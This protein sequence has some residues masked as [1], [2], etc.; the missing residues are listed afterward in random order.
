M[1]IQLHRWR[2]AK[3]IRHYLF[4]AGL[5]VFAV[6]IYFYRVPSDPPGFYIDESSI[7]YNAHTISHS[8]GDEY[9]V[10]WPLYFRAFGEFKNPTLVYLLAL[11]F[12][13]TGPSIL[14]ARV[15]C[16][17][18]GLTAALLLAVLAWKLSGQFMVGMLI[19]LSAT[20]TPWL[21]ESSRLVFEAAAYPLI[22][23]A[24]LLALHRATGR[25]VW[26][27]VDTILVATTLALLT[28]SYS[29]GRLLGPLLALGLISFAGKRN[30]RA[31]ATTLT[32]YAVTLLPMIVFAFRH[33]GALSTRFKAISYLGAGKSILEKVWQFSI[34]YLQD[35][36]PWTMLFVGENN[37]RDH[38]G[39]MGSVLLVTFVIA[40]AGLAIVIT[41]LRRN[42]WWRFIVYGLF[43]SVVPAALTVNDFPQ[44]RLIAFPVFLHVLM[45]PALKRLSV[46]GNAK[47][48]RHSVF[49]Q[50]RLQSVLLLAVSVL[51]VLQ[52]LYFQFLFHRESLTRWYF[53]DARFAR[54][55]LN[56]ALALNRDRIHL[57]DPP[58]ESGYI[59]SLWYG[60]LNGVD[61]NKFVRAD[62]RALLP[63]DSVVIST[64]RTCTNCRLLARSL[65]YIVYVVLPSSAEPN[66]A[67][68]PPEA[69]RAQI[70][71][72]HNPKLLPN[73]NA[74]T[75][76]VTVK[77]TSAASW[78]CLSDAQGRHAVV[79]RARWLT[80][81]GT[82]LSDA[83]RAEL[84]YDLE[85]GDV[86]DVDLPVITPPLGE[87]VLEIDLVQEPNRWFS[88]NGS[89]PL[90]LTI[91]SRPG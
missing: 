59:Q 7:A 65:N 68:L 61:V 6:A 67:A 12:K 25:A 49:P 83:G 36:N 37:P 52:G 86:N 45:V 31:V 90:R 8:G 29:I 44:L 58:G 16:A 50:R 77:N 84:N 9:G 39:G 15:L 56:P 66:I 38:A 34:H 30:R 63:A 24:F 81:D 40:V 71:L 35:I 75:L 23:V 33:P 48:S 57:F 76:R 82:L 46:G 19:G 1:K 89:Q 41:R 51:I 85:P 47:D 69:F 73:G 11:V 14:V 32:A 62:R 80:P 78:P 54:K 53:M 88:Q 70:S 43:V 10:N 72:R 91:Q 3:P 4:C 79:V 13:V 5:I 55:V 17:L 2:D 42:A 22:V 28:Y 74:E 26:R 27:A 21:Y 60:T 20:L 64:E 18:L 87:C